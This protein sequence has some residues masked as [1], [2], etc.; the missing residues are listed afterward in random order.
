MEF[1]QDVHK[2][3]CLST[4]RMYTGCTHKQNEKQKSENH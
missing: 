1:T 4:S 2:N 3:E